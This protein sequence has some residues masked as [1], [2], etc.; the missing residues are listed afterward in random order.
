[1]GTLLA[2]GNRGYLSAFKRT[3]PWSS[4]YPGCREDLPKLADAQ[5]DGAIRNDESAE[6]FQLWVE[7]HVAL[8]QYRRRPGRMR[9]VHTEVPAALQ[10]RGLADRLAH[11]GLEFARA[12]GLRVIPACPFV[13]AYIGRHP[14][15][16]SLVRQDDGADPA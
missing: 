3:S 11:A 8:L 2:G 9:F 4:A 5:A 13:A 1:M 7:G 15:Y 10:G 16:H 14:E 6:Q 12:H